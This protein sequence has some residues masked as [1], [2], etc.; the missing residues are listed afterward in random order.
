MACDSECLGC[1]CEVST[2]CITLAK[3]LTCFSKDLPIG[4]DLTVVFDA[5]CSKFAIIDRAL[6]IQTADANVNNT[7]T[8]TSLIGTGI[9]SVTI[10]KDRLVVGSTIRLRMRGNINSTA[11]PTGTLELTFGGTTITGAATTI[12]S[13]DD[14]FDIIVEITV[15]TIGAAGTMVL[16]AMYHSD[17]DDMDLH[18]N[19]AVALNTTIAQ[20]LELKWTWGTAHA[21]NT[22]ESQICTLEVLDYNAVV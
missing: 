18:N 2:E 13:S 7:V 15:R 19:A 21:N 17:V 22:I 11:T 14:G 20:L 16:G 4:T 8:K 1:N 10:K 6:F 3:K 9:G 5:I 12:N